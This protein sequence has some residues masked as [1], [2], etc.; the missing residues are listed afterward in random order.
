MTGLGKRIANA[1]RRRLA[2]YGVDVAEYFCG[3]VGRIRSHR[4][5]LFLYRHL[6]GVRIGKHSSI[7]YGCQF[8]RPGGV[9]IG[10][11]C[12]IGHCCFLDGRKGIEIH[13]NVSIAGETA[14]FTLQHDPQSSSFAAVGGPVVVEDYVFTG[15]RATILPNVTVG[16]GA[17]IAACAVVTK[18]VDEYTIVGGVPARKI[19]ER[20]R[21]LSYQLR[22][23][24]LLH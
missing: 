14:I 22:Y 10:D 9:S 5:R 12:V 19:G 23:A 20:N 21:D 11:N 18:D 15:S 4:V 6:F 8:Y 13:D 7:H 16:K 17:G 24:K 1:L 3:W 2:V